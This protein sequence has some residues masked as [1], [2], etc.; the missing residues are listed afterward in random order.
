[1]SLCLIGDVHGNFDILRKNM[2]KHLKQFPDDSFIAVGDM[3]C[4]FPRSQSSILPEYIKFIRGNHDSPEVCRAHPNYLGDYG[5]KEIEGKKVFWLSGA[6]SIDRA[7]RIEGV[8]WWPAEELTI[9]ELNNAMDLYLEYKPDVVVSHDGPSQATIYLL[10]RFVLNSDT[11]YREQSPIPT[12]TGQALT[13]MFEAYQPKLH[14]FGHWHTSW[15]KKIKG[16]VFVC[17]N[18]LEFQR[19]DEINLTEER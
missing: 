9:A 7:F 6:W 16:T 13:A 1:M 15:I 12:R 2:K 4:G 10:N 19:L 17:L 14:F 3:G 8:S 5:V 18:E 11:A